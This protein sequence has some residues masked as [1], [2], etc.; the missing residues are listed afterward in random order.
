MSLGWPH[1]K[2]RAST[3]MV[4]ACPA[5]ALLCWESLCSPSPSGQAGLVSSSA[6]SVVSMLQ[7]GSFPAF[8]PN[9]VKL[10]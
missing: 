6:V 5:A 4:L 9:F 7:F 2:S 8:L 3:G 1:M 10:M